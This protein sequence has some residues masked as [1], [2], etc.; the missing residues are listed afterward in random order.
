MNNRNIFF[1]LALWSF[2]FVTSFAQKKS[3]EPD[4]T[5]C[6]WIKD[7]GART[8]PSSRGLD[9]NPS[10]F[11][12]VGDGITMCTEFIQDAIDQCAKNGGGVVRFNTGIYLTGSIFLKSNVILDIP[13][14]VRIIG[15]QDIKDYPEIPG[16]VAGIEME[17]PAALINIIDQQNVA[18]TGEG[19][20][21]GDGKVFW[22]KYRAMRKEYDPKGL[23]WVVDYDCKRPRGII[24]ENSKDVTLQDFVLYRPGFW[25]V[26]ILYSEYIT[27]EGMTI[28][29]NIE[30]RGPSTDGIDIDSS[31]RILV[32]NCYINCNDDNFCLKAGRDADGLRVNKPCQYIVIRDCVAGHGDG[33]F[34]CGSET[35]GGIKNV[36]IYNMQGLGT[37]YGLRFKSTS[38]R[39]GTIENIYI[40][41][42]KM[43]G[44]RD[45]FVV[46]LNWHP[47]YSNSLLP[48]GYVYE[49][50]PVHWKKLLEKVDPKDG[51]PKFKN[52]HFENVEAINAK[53]CI[54]VTGL[55]ESTIDQFRFKDVSFTGENAG[56][57]SYAK[58]WSFE[59]FKVTGTKESK[60]EMDNNKGVKLK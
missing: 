26:H 25:S 54:K 58:D 8:M 12:A 27:V 23:R 34:T 57:I 24:I 17:W 52:I 3:F 55:E 29:N 4:L 48:D 45:P 60:V 16:R 18:I 15:S 50:L 22:D 9:Y 37:K 39:G 42:V 56:K 35:S 14:G 1:L 47:T 32:Q 31:E 40:Y 28:N 38:Q 51:L 10:D 30:A 44:V 33:L 5:S 7:V 2:V 19:V 13:K 11:G 49:E 20:V 41:N 21:D 46:N 59:N 36:L 43:D 6:T 53:T